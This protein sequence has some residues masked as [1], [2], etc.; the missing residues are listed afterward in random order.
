M[1]K[2]NRSQLVFSNSVRTAKIIRLSPPTRIVILRLGL[3]F[4]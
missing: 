2:M 4:G 3:F 1:Q